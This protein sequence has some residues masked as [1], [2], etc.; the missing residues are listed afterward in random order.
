MT[1]KKRVAI[2][3]GTFNPPHI[4]HVMAAERFFEKIKPDILYIIPA[5]IPPHKEYAGSVTAQERLEM[6][7]LAFGHIENVQ[8]SDL[9]IKR[10]GRS[11]TYLTLQELASED[12]DLYLL[13]GTDM[14]LT[15]DEWKNPEI[16][17]NLATICVIR[18]EN[19]PSNILLIKNKSAEFVDKFNARIIEIPTD[20]IEISSS[21]LRDISARENFTRNYLP[22]TVDTY[23]RERN[24]YK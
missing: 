12:R 21:E 11:Y 2:F 24:L 18:R 9:E 8:I 19:D 22:S 4:A 1:D 13:C 16:I 20:V 6:C 3:G 17:F 15:L 23:I 5:G 10:E 14:F 7:S